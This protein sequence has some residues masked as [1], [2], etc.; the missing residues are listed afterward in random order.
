LRFPGGVAVW[1][2]GRRVARRVREIDVEVA[3]DAFRVVV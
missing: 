2:D 1:L 3:P